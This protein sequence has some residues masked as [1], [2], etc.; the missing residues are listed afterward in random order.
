MP[1]DVKNLYQQKKNTQFVICDNEYKFEKYNIF[2][3]KKNETNNNLSN[4]K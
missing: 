3:C 1:L 2:K 4:L